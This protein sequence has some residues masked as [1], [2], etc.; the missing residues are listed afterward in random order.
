LSECFS[1]VS[2]RKKMVWNSLN[3]AILSDIST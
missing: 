3:T 2:S 1:L